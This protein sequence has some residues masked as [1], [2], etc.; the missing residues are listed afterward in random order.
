MRALLLLFVVQVLV[1]GVVI[2][3]IHSYIIIAFYLYDA[4]LVYSRK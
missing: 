3:E 1:S 2:V 4:V